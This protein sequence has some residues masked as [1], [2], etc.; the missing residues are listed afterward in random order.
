M[1][2]GGRTIFHRHNVSAHQRCPV[3]SSDS[4][5]KRSISTV[6]SAT[7]NATRP[8]EANE[9]HASRT[10][11]SVECQRE[12]DGKTRVRTEGGRR[13]EKNRRRKLPRVACAA[14]MQRSWSA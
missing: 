14:W 3:A 12:G 11:P 8:D 10:Q 6:S 7:S 1:A 5:L 9:G 2:S 4:V 13:A